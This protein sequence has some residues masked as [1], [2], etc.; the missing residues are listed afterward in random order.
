MMTTGQATTHHWNDV[1]INSHFFSRLFTVSFSSNKKKSLKTANDSLKWTNFLLFF[2]SF[3][4]PG[5]FNINTNTHLGME[6]LFASP[7]ASQTCV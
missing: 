7:T 1:T 2:P 4:V 3:T 6:T 5:N